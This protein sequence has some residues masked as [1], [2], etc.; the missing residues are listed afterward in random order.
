MD[1]NYLLIW[2]VGFINLLTLFRTARSKHQRRWAWSSALVLSVLAAFMAFAPDIA[3]L[4][5]GGGCFTRLRRFAFDNLSGLTRGC[6]VGCRLRLLRGRYRFRPFGLRGLDRC[7]IENRRFGGGRSNLCGRIRLR[8]S[9]ELVRA[10]LIV[11]TSD[12]FSIRM[13]D[14]VKAQD[15]P[16]GLVLFLLTYGSDSSRGARLDVTDGLRKACKLQLE[17]YNRQKRF[18]MSEMGLVTQPL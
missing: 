11:R 3:G 8:R 12:D 5:S 9:G 10:D 2:L 4:V 18:E 6:C 14:A 13:V 16:K 7:G 1:L 17:D 15:E